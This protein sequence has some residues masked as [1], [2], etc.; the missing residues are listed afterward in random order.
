MNILALD[1]GMSKTV[2]CVLDTDSNTHTFVTIQTEPGKVRELILTKQPDQVIFEVCSI[3][4]WV[5]DLC[6][7]LGCRCAI[8]NPSHEAWRWRNVKRKSDRLDALK[9]ARLAAMDQLPTVHVPSRQTRQWRALIAYRH[10]LV[11]RRT[12]VKNHI[13]ALL[14]THG[15]RLPPGRGGWTMAALSELHDL[16]TSTEAEALWKTELRIELNQFDAVRTAIEQVEQELDSIAVERPRVALVQS[17]PG[18]GPR[19]AELIVSV[20][21]DPHRFRTGRQVGSYAGLTPRQYQ[22]GESN[23]RGRISRQGNPLLRAMLVEVSWVSLRYNQRIRAI[24][25]R[26]CRGTRSRRKIAIVAVARRLLVWAWAILRDNTPWQPP[27]P[28]LT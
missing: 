5:R 28:A 2:A 23:R 13:R 17:I 12:R 22:S 10:T 26:T 15:H 9:L 27:S 7:E 20:I 14:L 16:A 21:D 4:G 3:S 24:Y 19:L 18:V 25:E 1:L 11:R 6:E 8:A